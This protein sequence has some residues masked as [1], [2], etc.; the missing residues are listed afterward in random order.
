MSVIRRVRLRVYSAQDSFGPGLIGEPYWYAEVY[1]TSVDRSLW[2]AGYGSWLEAMRGGL[3]ALAEKGSVGRSQ[4]WDDLNEDI[5]DPE[6]RD[7]YLKHQLAEALC[8]QE[9]ATVEDLAPESRA[10]LFADL[11]AL[12]PVIDAFY[13]AVGLAKCPNCYPQ[14]MTA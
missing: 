6:F 2:T 5:K 11:D 9:G 10:A 14:E 4:F 3:L 13:R 1:E 7:A 12:L 8:V